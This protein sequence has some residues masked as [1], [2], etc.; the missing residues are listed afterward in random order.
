M[1]L[2]QKV[3]PPEGDTIYGQFV[4][5]GTQIGYCAWGLHRNREIFGEDAEIFRPERWL[6]VDEEKLHSMNRVNDFVFGG[7]KYACLG[8]PIAWI[9]ISKAI[10][11]VSLI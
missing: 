6:E 11:E 8:K 10:A 9:E 7:G 4:P 5:G 2:M 1:G 3:V